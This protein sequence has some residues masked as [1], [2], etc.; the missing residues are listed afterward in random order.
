MKG[1]HWEA[2]FIGL[3]VLAGYAQAIRAVI[4]ALT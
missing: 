3:F 2:V 1:I 4:G